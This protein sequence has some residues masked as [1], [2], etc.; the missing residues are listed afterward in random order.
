[1][2]PELMGTHRDAK[3]TASFDEVFACEGYRGDQDTGEIASCERVS[4]SAGYGPSEKSVSTGRSFSA[5]IISKQSFATT[6]GITTSIGLTAAFDSK[7][8]HRSAK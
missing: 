4:R 1:M 3:F 6:S 5:V 8:P 2:V 7:C